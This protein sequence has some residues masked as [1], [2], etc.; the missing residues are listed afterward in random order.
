[1]SHPFLPGIAVAAALLVASGAA[2]AQQAPAGQSMEERL[3]N[4]L[5]NTTAQLQ[6]AQNELAVLKAGAGGQPAAKAGAAP[7]D[8][9]ALKKELEAARAQLASE[10]QSREALRQSQQQGQALVKSVGAQIA[11]YRGAYDE[12]LKMAR[13][14]DAERQRAGCRN[15]RAE[16]RADPVRSQER[17]VVRGGP[18][19]A[20]GLRD[21]RSRHGAE[22]R[23]SPLP[24]RAACATSRSRSKVRRQALRRAVLRRCGGAGC[25]GRSARPARPAAQSASQ[26]DVP[27][28]KRRTNPLPHISDSRTSP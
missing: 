26:P 8:V 14:L 6:Q 28:R 5:R 23:A 3:R 7:A 22:R 27:R 1:M 9:D 15:H 13:G 21:R 17:A 2:H 19:G 24:R 25:R 20:A 12:L 16:D 18:G 4:Q 10:R 11:Q